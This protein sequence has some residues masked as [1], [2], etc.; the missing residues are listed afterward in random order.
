[1]HQVVNSPHTVG[2]T[3]AAVDDAKAF[4]IKGQPL[5]PASL[6]DGLDE[7]PGELVSG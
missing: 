4:D 5:V 7:E 6:D 2:R 1:M 3:F